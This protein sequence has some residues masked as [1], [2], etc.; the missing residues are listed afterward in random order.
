MKMKSKSLIILFTKWWE[1]SCQWNSKNTSYEPTH[2]PNWLWGYVFN[3]NELYDD[4][5]CKG[6]KFTFLGKQG[7]LFFTTTVVLTVIAQDMSSADLHVPDIG[8]PLTS[9]MTDPPWTCLHFPSSV[10]FNCVIVHDWFLKIK[11]K[12]A[13][14]V[15]QPQ[16]ID[17]SS[18]STTN[19][20]CNY[21]S[22]PKNGGGY[23]SKVWPYCVFYVIF[24]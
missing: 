10:L 17:M 3:Y 5:R 11:V 8:Y 21:S 4:S 6:S 1:K 23:H 20:Q 14:L 16:E 22:A 15:H 12:N 13:V 18:K 7:A 2:S 24:N 9:A 19:F